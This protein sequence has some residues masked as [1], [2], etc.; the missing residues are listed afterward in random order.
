MRGRIAK[1]LARIW[2]VSWRERPT[3]HD[4]EELDANTRR[5]GLVIRVRWALVGALVLFSVVAA[6]VYAE[7]SI[8]YS[9]LWMNMRIPAAALVFV[10]FYNTYY[11]LTY[12]QLGNIAVLNHAQLLF[13]VLVVGVLVYYSGGVYSWFDA[14]FLLFILEAALIM[15]R[16]R[17]V[18]VIAA[19][20]AGV[21]GS[22]LGA[23]FLGWLPHVGMPFVENGLHDNGTFVL[24]RYLWEVAMLGGTATVS[25]LMT[26]ALHE[27][28][29]TLVETSVTD[30]TTGLYNRVF[31]YRLL[32]SEVARAAREGRHLSVVLVD[33]DGFGDYNRLFG[34]ERGNR[35][36][37]EI[38]GLLRE[39]FRTS[40]EGTYE[41]SAVCRFGGEEYVV[42]VPEPIVAGS[43]PG[44][45]HLAERAREAVSVLRVDDS[46]VTVSLGVAAYPEDGETADALLGAADAALAVASAGEGNSVVFARD[47]AEPEDADAPE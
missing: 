35:M 47:I 7:S 20:C 43:A 15:P 16:K 24:V 19:A 28:E 38:G 1:R 26:L 30:E 44:V 4:I 2:K 6:L 22:V 12:K 14:M 27:R 9:A 31:C 40:P 37:R 45:G 8:P 34:H 5:V 17:S 32:R 41:P 39:V 11:Q 25:S 10:L 23:E 33:V 13:D 46:C 36:L 29:R 42:I 21:Y 3:Q 18:W